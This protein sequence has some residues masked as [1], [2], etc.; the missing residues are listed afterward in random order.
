MSETKETT[1][2]IVLSTAR[3]PL[4]LKRTIESGHVQQKFSHGRSKSVVVEKKRKRSLAGPE[5]DEAPAAEARPAKQSPAAPAAAKAAPQ[6][7]V[8]QPT[9]LRTL[10][11]GERAARA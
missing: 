9:V 6:P 5:V 1:D 10:S 3:K 4:S 2:K 8:R 11:E 7:Q